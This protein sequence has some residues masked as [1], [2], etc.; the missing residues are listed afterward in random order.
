MGIDLAPKMLEEARRNAGARGL[1][2]TFAIGDAVAPEFPAASFDMVVSR[3]FL[4]T[5]RE[6]EAALKNWRALLRPDGRVVAI[7]GFWF[8]QAPEAGE[9]PAQPGLFEEHY[10]AETKKGLPIM[11]MAD[12]EPV[13]ALF[14]SAG[15][16]EVTTTDLPQL[17]NEDAGGAIPYV[18]RAMKG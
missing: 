18:I 3:H 10:T 14:R 9:E 13:V 8:A 11:A 2:A 12:P 7:D 5:L 4:W 6:P 17:P 15:F 16:G 1:S